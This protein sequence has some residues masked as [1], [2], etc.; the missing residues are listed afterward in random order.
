MDALTAAIII[1]I[2]GFITGLDAY[3]TKAFLALMPIIAGFITGLVFGD[4][5]T[6]AYVGGFVQL[7]SLG[8][9]PIG[10]AVPPDFAIV[11]VVLVALFTV[12]NLPISELSTVLLLVVPAGILS[13]YF[14]IFAR[15]INVS[16]IRSAEAEFE[17]GNYDKGLKL[18]FL[19]LLP[20]A[21]FRAA[22]YFIAAFIA[23]TVGADALKS[24][25]QS[26]PIWILRG[27]SVAGALLP[28][29]GLGI[30]ISFLAFER[31]KIAFYLPF[32]I[33]SLIAF[34]Y[35]FSLVLIIA[36]LYAWMR[37]RKASK[38]AGGEKVE[39]TRAGIISDKTLKS[40]ILRSSFL[41]E[42]SWNYERMQAL[43]YLFSIF[44]A[45]KEIYKD[46]ETFK[47]AVREHLEFFNTNPFFAPMI[48]GM[49]VATEESMPGDF[50]LV[51]NIKVGL[52]GTF[53]GLGDSLIYLAIGGVLLIVGSSFAQQAL[54]NPFMA[55][56]PLLVLIIFNAIFIP[57]RIY[58]GYLGYRRGLGISKTF[59]GE[60]VGP[61]R[62]T[63]EWLALFSVGAILPTIMSLRVY[64]LSSYL[65]GIDATLGLIST[66]Q[67]LGSLIGLIFVLFVYYL[68]RKRWPV[69]NILAFLFAIGFILGA[70]GVLSVVAETVAG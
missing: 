60:R 40:I 31:N 36:G 44:P 38:A 52:M 66:N 11:A 68:R 35:T 9:I 3:S 61:L 28:A 12:G 30:L 2:L 48:V 41:L 33:V 17:K 27:L 46:E 18:H 55:W 1:A 37:I 29:L 10:G 69:L 42:C 53:A 24:M 39:E 7:A 67:F 32:L 58:F 63:F 45:L 21:G 25:M 22:A 43:G 6:G 49:D 13:M 19:G 20:L 4:V 59:T 56:V 50:E 34:P 64:F 65:E 23:L 70:L 51:R 8:L 54:T 14:D 62:E 15:T 16:V 5:V 26:L 47:G 57:F